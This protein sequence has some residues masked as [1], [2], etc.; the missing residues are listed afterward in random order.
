MDLRDKKVLITGGKGFLG[1]HVADEIKRLGLHIDSSGRQGFAIHCRWAGD[2]L[3]L[4]VLFIH[5]HKATRD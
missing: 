1:T 3:S 5:A 4:P 2:C